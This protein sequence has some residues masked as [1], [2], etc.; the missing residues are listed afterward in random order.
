MIHSAGPNTTGEARLAYTLAFEL[1]PRPS[2][3][4]R[5][6]DW[7]EDRQSAD[8]LRR[9]AWLRR[10][11]IVVELLRRIRYHEVYKPR[12]FAFELRRLIAKRRAG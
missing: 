3:A 10:G 12:R 7:N 8:V 5:R 1:P 11:G 6:F 4:V 2:A 9:Q